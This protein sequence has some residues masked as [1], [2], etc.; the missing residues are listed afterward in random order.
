MSDS[1][2]TAF[3]EAVEAGDSDAVLATF[4]NDIVFN[5]PVVHRPI[6]GRQALALVIPKLLTVWQGLRYVAELDGDETVGLVFTAGVGGR[7]ADGIDLLRFNDDGLINQI[8]V[9][10]RPLSALQTFA[11]EVQAAMAA[12]GPRQRPRVEGRVR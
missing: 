12:G 1:T 7:D 10:V 9:M 4:A 8:T 6:E 11:N 5:S 2:A 3:R